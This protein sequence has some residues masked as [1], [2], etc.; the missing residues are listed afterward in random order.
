[1]LVST[2]GLFGRFRRDRCDAL[3]F[4]RFGV[5]VETDAGHQEGTLLT[6]QFELRLDG[7]TLDRQVGGVTAMVRSVRWLD[8]DHARLGLEFV[9]DRLAPK[10]IDALE[11]LE[12][13]I[14]RI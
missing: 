3:D 4:N 1:M 8:D 11:H 12:I 6:L 7:E 2:G 14:K 13:A 9:P 5:C 10:Q